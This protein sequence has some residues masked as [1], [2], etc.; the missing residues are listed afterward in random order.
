M[1]KK[2]D[3]LQ[4]IVIKDELGNYSRFRLSKKLLVFLT[5]AVGGAL[6][7]LLTA[8][9]VLLKEHFERKEERAE[10]TR[11]IGELEEELK[12]LSSQNRNLKEEVAKLKE[13]RERTVKEL[14]RR[15]S[16]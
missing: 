3:E 7:S 16:E 14:A 1:G 6:L 2:D 11:R 12:E 13:E 4:V 8:S 9:S 5:F 10:L 15:V